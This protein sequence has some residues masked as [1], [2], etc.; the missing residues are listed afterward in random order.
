MQEFTATTL[1]GGEAHR[2]L[3]RL[4]AEDPRHPPLRMPKTLAVPEVMRPHR[5][6]AVAVP[7]RATLFD[8]R[9]ESTDQAPQ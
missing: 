5:I 6:I 9:L 1:G 2:T 3:R 7:F 4:D 8:N